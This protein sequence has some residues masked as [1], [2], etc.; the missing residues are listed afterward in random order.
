MSEKDGQWQQK[1]KTMRLVDDFNSLYKGLEKTSKVIENF[2]DSHSEK[3]K[4]MEVYK[5]LCSLYDLFKSE[6][7][8]G[9]QLREVVFKQRQEIKSLK[10]DF[11][12]CLKLFSTM[13]KTDIKSMKSAKDFVENFKAP[14]VSSLHALEQTQTELV[15]EKE[16]TTQLQTENEEIR[17]KLADLSNNLQNIEQNYKFKIDR[18][19]IELEKSTD[20]NEEL[21]VENVQLKSDVSK[22]KRALIDKINTDTSEKVQKLKLEMKKLEEENSQLKTNY[23]KL[24]DEVTKPHVSK[25]ATEKEIPKKIAIQTPDSFRK[26]IILGIFIVK[27]KKSLPNYES[28]PELEILKEEI[29]KTK[30]KLAQMDSW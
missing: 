22:L 20:T 1:S 15:L 17:R 13:A 16:R 8:A 27:L 9:M 5:V 11:Q 18:L 21:K 6:I 4:K 19:K 14:S 3:Y 24:M 29:K 12:T 23:S 10:G 30:S 7:N 25:I 2:I 28:T 26:L